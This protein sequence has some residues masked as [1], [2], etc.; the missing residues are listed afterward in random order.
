[1]KKVSTTMVYMLLQ[2]PSPKATK[3]RQYIQSKMIRHF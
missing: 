1:M 2:S 3:L